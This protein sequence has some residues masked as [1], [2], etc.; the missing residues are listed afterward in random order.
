MIVSFDS[1]PETARVWVYQS[2]RRLTDQEVAILEKST[3]EFLSDWEAHGAPLASGF[4][5]LHHQFLIIGVDEN[6]NPVTGCSTDTKVRFIQ[7][8]KNK[9]G[10]DFFNRTRIALMVNDEVHLVELEDL[11]K[12]RSTVPVQQETVTFNNLVN[13]KKQLV[14]DWMKPARETWIARYL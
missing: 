10:V 12:G 11:K 5:L 6:A 4:K 13:T 7:L 9:L 8:M 2:D 14:S 1:L 3:S